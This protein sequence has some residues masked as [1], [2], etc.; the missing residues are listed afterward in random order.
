LCRKRPALPAASEPVRQLLG[1]HYDGAGVGH[2]VFSA[3]R[4]EFKLIKLHRSLLAS[5]LLFLFQHAQVKRAAG[6]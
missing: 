6:S 4:R 5:S 1:Q 3:F 2:V